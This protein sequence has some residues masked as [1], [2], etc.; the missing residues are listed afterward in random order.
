MSPSCLMPF[1]LI[2]SHELQPTK[3]PLA[4]YHNTR[5]FCRG[6]HTLSKVSS[7][8][9]LC[10][11]SHSHI[12]RPQ[13]FLAHFPSPDT[14][15]RSLRF[16]SPKTGMA[17]SSALMHDLPTVGV[18]Q[19]KSRMLMPR[20]QPRPSQ[21]AQVVRLARHQQNEDLGLRAG[22]HR[23]FITDFCGTKALPAPGAR[24]GPY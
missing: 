10:L 24:A 1:N 18:S 14:Q 7:G 2:A 9:A 8:G 17:T 23:G 21:A 19:K 15:G 5:S 3:V 20:L 16:P 6:P 22:S 4:L 11:A 12:H 13:S